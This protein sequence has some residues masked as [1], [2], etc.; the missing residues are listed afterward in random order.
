MCQVLTDEE[1]TRIDKA[2][3]FF[4][5]SERESEIVVALALEEEI[6]DLIKAAKR[7]SAPRP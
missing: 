3:D 6:R 7:R 5:S 4:F 2:F 1:F